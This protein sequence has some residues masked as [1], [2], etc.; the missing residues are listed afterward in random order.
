MTDQDR[1]LDYQKIFDRVKNHLLTQNAKAVRNLTTAGQGCAYRGLNDTKCAIGCL[2]DDAFYH[3][4]LEGCGVQE[5]L[6]VGALCAS[7]GTKMNTK[8]ISFLGE[9]QIIHDN[10]LPLA[11]KTE[12]RSFALYHQL[13][14]KE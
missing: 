5:K 6:V 1:S 7:L 10:Y 9:L 11:W 8:D 14:W 12:L 3:K 4:E 13:M 2:I